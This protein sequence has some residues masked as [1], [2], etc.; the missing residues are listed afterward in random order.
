ME[1]LGE[2]G[3]KTGEQPESERR[4]KSEA[5]SRHRGNDRVAEK[6]KVLR[7]PSLQDAPEMPTRTAAAKLPSTT[8][9]KEALELEIQKKKKVIG[10]I[11]LNTLPDGGK[12]LKDQLK[13]LEDQLSLLC[14]SATSDTGTKGC[15]AKDTSVAA[16]NSSRGDCR[17]DVAVERA[18]RQADTRAERPPVA[19]KESKESA[20]TKISAR[21]CDSS[22]ESR[23][24]KG[25]QTKDSADAHRS[26]ASASRGDDKKCSDRLSQ[27]VGKSC[28]LPESTGKQRSPESKDNRAQ[29]CSREHLPADGDLS[30]S[31][32][33][34]STAADISP[35]GMS[36]STSVREA[37]MVPGPS[38]SAVSKRRPVSP[39]A[40][41]SSCQEDPRPPTSALHSVYDRRVLLTSPLP[42]SKAAA[43]SAA[44]KKGA[45]SE[46]LGTRISRCLSEHCTA[47][48][49]PLIQSLSSQP[50]EWDESPQPQGVQTSLMAHQRQ[51]LRWMLWREEQEAPGGILADAMGLGKTLTML[52]LVE[53]AAVKGQGTPPRG[54]T[55]VVCPLSLLHQWEEEVQ[56]HLP[57]RW[58]VHV[59]HG[60]NRT[61]DPEELAG[62]DLVVTTYDTISSDWARIDA[63]GNSA[64]SPLFTVKWRRLVLDEAHN[65]RNLHTRRAK[66]ACA[67]L[68]WSRWALTGTPVHNDLNDMR[69]LLKFLQCH[70]FDDDIFWKQW[71]KENP[72][73]EAL[74]MVMKCVLL[75]RTKEQMGKDGKPLVPLPKKSIVL[76]K[77]SL[78]GTEAKVYKELDEWSRSSGPEKYRDPVTGRELYR[79]TG[80]RR[81]VM[82]IRLQQACSHPALLKKKVLEDA[83]IDTDELLSAG[84]AG[85]QLS[86]DSAAGEDSLD[87]LNLDKYTSAREFDS[88]YV[89]CKIKTLLDMLL[90]VR[91]ESNNQDKSVVVS[92]WTSLLSL[93]RHHLERRGIPSVTIQGSVPGHQR[94]SYVAKFNEQRGGPTVMLLSL[95]AGGVGLNLVGGNHMFVLDVHWNPALEAQAFDRIHRVGQT[96]TVVINRLICAGTIEERILE[97]QKHKQR[98][99]ESVVARRRLT[100][101]DYDFLFATSS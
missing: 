38:G 80:S 71:V 97:L 48:L 100:A 74:A 76:H 91:E 11:K 53:A 59:H 26:S 101:N 22:K 29:S 84:M 93:V 25:S 89:S 19:A 66:A 58:Q 79:N 5:F 10:T 18:V 17:S 50:D 27:D 94:A 52:S 16:E 1:S 88:A 6:Q 15:A 68:A 65:I 85:L 81:F 86:D 44:G 30:K 98:L 9:S 90:K 61:A 40:R 62:C 82:L 13:E 4:E 46:T 33:Q 7:P 2:C 39:V 64:L 43:S 21:E 92:R 60:R 20:P 35:K 51:A 47:R 32:F 67:L 14:L 73:P 78:E 34:C 56:R 95:E 31:S 55:L 87:A 8:K 96:K 49:Q 75:R 70:P 42:L 54:G 72:G 99:A 57:D 63:T 36:S 45:T 69:S 23:P 12:R 83:A 3:R 37:P 28:V 77:L 24:D 41:V